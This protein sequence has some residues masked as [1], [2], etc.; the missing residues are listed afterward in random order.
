LSTR[1]VELWPADRPHLPIA[2]IAEWFATY[3]YLPKL[4]DRVVLEE[5]IRDAVAKLDPKFAYA[6]GFDAASGRYNGLCWQKAPPMGPVSASALLVRPEIAIAQLRPVAPPRAPEPG[7]SAPSGGPEATP[8]I[9]PEPA[10][11]RQPRRFFG[12]VEIDMVRPVKAFDAIL[13]AV[14]MELQRTKGAKVKL[15]L[16]DRGRR[17]GWILR[18]RCRGSPRQRTPTQIQGRVDR[19]RVKRGA[20][21]Q[22]VLA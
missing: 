19:I 20:R 22:R 5:A 9:A 14:V 6:E 16:R 2:E 11:N 13:S 8:P 4:R 18:S 7:P 17:G 21:R 10:P 1:L 15:T 12:S 3:V